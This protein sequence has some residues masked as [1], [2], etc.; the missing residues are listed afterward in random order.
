M[1]QE[2]HAIVNPAS[3]NGRAKRLWLPVAARLRAQGI[4]VWEHQTSG[5]GDATRLAR[6]LVEAGAREFLVAGGDGTTNEVVNGLFANGRPLAP[7]AILSIIP[8]GTGRDFSR[9]LGIRNVDHAVSLLSAGKVCAVDVGRIAYRDHGAP[10]ERYFVNVADV[11]LGAETAALLNRSSKA[12]GGFL[13]YLLG[14]TRTILTFRGR[15]ARVVVDGETVFHGP[16][17]MV[18][19]ANGRYHAGGMDM[20]PMASLTD[21]LLEI[22]VLR[23]VPRRTLLGSL[24][25]R[26]YLGRHVGHAAV[27]HRTGREVEIKAEDGLPF[28]TDGEQPG[29]TDLRADVLHRALLVRTAAPLCAPAVRRVPR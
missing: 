10:C 20:A 12:L 5:R 15:V 26:V 21:G 29:T 27:L 18:V 9:S 24:L 6:E 16:I 3:G 8:C 28:E 7:D 11:G 2:F 17:G 1:I 4:T 14:A 23:E 19:L 25:P 13:A 22:L